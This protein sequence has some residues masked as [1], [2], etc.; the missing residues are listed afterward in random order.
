MNCKCGFELPDDA[1]FCPSCGKR[2]PRP[3]PPLPEIAGTLSIRQV[4]P[5]L[6][7]KEAASLLRI[8]EWMVYELVRQKKIPHF[9]VGNRK[10]FR[11]QELLEWAGTLDGPVTTAG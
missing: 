5:I 3:K 7:A 4:E 1:N 9:Q 8:S 2:M 11:A 6:T 10:R